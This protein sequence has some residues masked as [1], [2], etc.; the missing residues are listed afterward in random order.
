MNTL[1]S[2]LNEVNFEPDVKKGY[3]LFS[4]INAETLV[5]AFLLYLNP[6]LASNVVDLAKFQKVVLTLKPAQDVIAPSF[7]V[8]NPFNEAGLTTD[9]GKTLPQSLVIAAQ[10]FC[11]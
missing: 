1:T 2:A 11:R 6:Y 10:K 4:S 3:S 8:P 5:T 7:K 9:S